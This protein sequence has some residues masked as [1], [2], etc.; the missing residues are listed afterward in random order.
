MVTRVTPRAPRGRRVARRGGDG[1][2]QGVGTGTGAKVFNREIID[3]KVG[4]QKPEL[5][6]G[7][8]VQNW[9]DGRV[10]RHHEYDHPNGH[11]F[12]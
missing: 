3:E 6:S 2:D 7:E 9:V 5:G 1:G 11:L 8:G 12:C 4:Q 10:D